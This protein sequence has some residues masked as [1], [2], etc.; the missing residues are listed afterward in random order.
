MTPLYGARLKRTLQKELVDEVAKLVLE[1]R[2]EPGDV[3]Y[4]TYVN[5]RLHIQR[6]TQEGTPPAGEA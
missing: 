4:V 5:Q 1:G 2:F 6:G 3:I